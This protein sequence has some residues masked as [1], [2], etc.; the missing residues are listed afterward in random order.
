ME[1]RYTPC[2]A[3]NKEAQRYEERARVVTE[4]KSNEALVRRWFEDVWN[5]KRA[6]VIEELI[7]PNCIARGMGPNGTDLHGPEGFKTA[8]SLFVGA[9]P[10]LHITLDEVVNGGD[11]VAAHFTCHATHGGDNMGMPATGLPV[12]FSGMTMARV[13]NGRII[14]GWN[15]IDLLSVMQQIQ[16]VAPATRLP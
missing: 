7:D 8:H 11:L 6:E 13:K 1:R 3:V 9:F 15:V 16:A 2:A 12:T 14:E 10:D 5:Q 4:E